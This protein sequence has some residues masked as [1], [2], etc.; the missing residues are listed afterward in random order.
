MKFKQS[1]LL[2]LSI[3]AML[4]SANSYAGRQGINFFYGVGLSAVAPDEIGVPS[5]LSI[6]ADPTAAASIMLGFEE[7]GWSLEATGFTSLE[8]GSNISLVDYSISGTDIGL[9]YRSIEK[10]GRY[11]KIKYAQSDVDIDFNV[12]GSTLTAETS[13]KSYTLGLGLRTSR[14]NRIEVDYTFHDSDDLSDAV[15]MI[16]IHYLWGGAPYLGKSF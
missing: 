1:L 9:A 7:D 14:E 15:H 12:S 10:H 13:G 3:S 11:Y 2:I 8:Q 4:L 5:I 16:S 6:E